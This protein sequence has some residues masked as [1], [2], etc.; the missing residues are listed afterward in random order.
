MPDRLIINTEARCPENRNSVPKTGIQTSILRG[1]RTQ[2][3][4]GLQIRGY[5][6]VL[7]LNGE[8]QQLWRA[9]RRKNRSEW[10]TALECRAIGQHWNNKKT[11]IKARRKAGERITVASWS[12]ANAPV[13]HRWLDEFGDFANRWDEFRATWKWAQSLEYTSARR[14]GLHGFVDLM[15][16]EAQLDYIKGER[17]QSQQPKK[18]DRSIQTCKSSRAIACQFSALCRRNRSRPV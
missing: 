16:T 1:D 14:P 2:H 11:I 6:P 4:L 7:T 17:R 15:N 3:K 8:K 13:T 5:R 9:W 18:A 10:Q 12:D